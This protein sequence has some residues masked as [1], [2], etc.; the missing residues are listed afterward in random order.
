MNGIEY[1]Y[2][3]LIKAS[4][5]LV[6]KAQGAQDVDTKAFL[7]RA[8]KGYKEKARSLTVEEACAMPKP[9]RA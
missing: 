3:R 1:E 2:E 7:F 9:Y 6:Q 8:S 5:R 4:D